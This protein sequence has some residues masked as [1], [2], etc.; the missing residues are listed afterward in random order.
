M[1]KILFFIIALFINT[2]VFSQQVTTYAGSPFGY[3]YLD[4]SGLVAQFKTPRGICIDSQGNIFIADAEITE[5]E[6]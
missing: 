2:L 3:G 5:L 1:S 4:G 6:K